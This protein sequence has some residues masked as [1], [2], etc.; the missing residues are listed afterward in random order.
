M[1]SIRKR[2]KSYSITVCKGYDSS[3]KKL[4]DTATFTPPPGLRPEKER[5]AA[6]AFAIE[7]EASIRRGRNVKGERTTLSELANLYLL[8]MVPS[9][10]LARTTYKDYKDR[11]NHRIIPAMGHIPIGN[12]RKKDVTD[13]ATM[14]RDNYRNPK[15]GKPLSE[16]SIQKDI[17]VA[18]I[19]YP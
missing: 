1:A 3:G 4:I 11:I 7:F 5:A 15:T 2:G 9:V 13:Y 10:D 19:F 8:D 14:L 16:S 17:A 6:E 18:G 12:I